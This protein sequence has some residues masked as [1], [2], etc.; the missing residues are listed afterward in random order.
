MRIC[1]TCAAK[2]GHRVRLPPNHIIHDPETQILKLRANPENI[3]IGADHPD[4]AIVFQ[5]A[6]C[7]SHPLMSELV[8]GFKARE[9][10]PLVSDAIDLALVG[11]GE[12]TLQLKIV[13]RVC[14]N[15]IDG[16]FRHRIHQFNA[17]AL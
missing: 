3:V 4:G 14:E 15:E 16:F 7:C 5:N 12:I 9:L 8:I 11:A 13:R 1:K 6:L 10:I 17:I 2:V